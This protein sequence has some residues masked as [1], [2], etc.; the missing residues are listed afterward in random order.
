MLPEF[1]S[2]QDKQAPEPHPRDRPHRQRHEHRIIVTRT[3]PSAHS[4]SRSH[5]F[6]QPLLLPCS[7]RSRSQAD[8]RPAYGNRSIVTN[9]WRCSGCCY[10]G[11]RVAALPVNPKCCVEAT[12]SAGLVR[13][14][15]VPAYLHGPY[16]RR[17]YGY[18]CIALSKFRFARTWTRIR[19]WLCW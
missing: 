5:S 6:T 4:R 16:H 1:N 2:P 7:E 15:R 13:G 12:S 18:Y 3:P 11:T 14:E 8:G 17:T 19:T 9:G 10:R